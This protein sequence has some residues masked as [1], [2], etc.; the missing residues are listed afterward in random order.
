MHAGIAALEGSPD[1][2]MAAY[3]E[4][5]AAWRDLGLVWDEALCAIDMVTLLDP[6]DPE[7]LAAAEA[8]RGTLVGLGA[9]P[10][11][12]RLDAAVTRSEPATPITE[13]VVDAN[14]IQD[15]CAFVT[16]GQWSPGHRFPGEKV[17]SGS[18]KEPLRCCPGEGAIRR[19]GTPSAIAPRASITSAAP[20][21]LTLPTHD[22]D[23]GAAGRSRSAITVAL[24]CMKAKGFSR[25]ARCKFLNLGGP[26]R[27]SVHEPGAWAR[28]QVSPRGW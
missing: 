13:E 7:V 25:Y 11:L 21:T 10:F 6:S 8:A 16:T 27:R 9:K 23:A 19:G 12:E 4:A 1:D 17:R 5:L 20:T 3:R 24:Q 18:P 14:Q 26:G 28:A 2:A 15:R 22:L